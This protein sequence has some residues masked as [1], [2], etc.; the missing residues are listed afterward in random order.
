MEGDQEILREE[1]KKCPRSDKINKSMN[2]R[3]RGGG[4][5]EAGSGRDLLIAYAGWKVL[6]TDPGVE[7]V[8]G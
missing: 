6:R 4:L 8:G 2:E 3:E 1:G 5:L 7:R